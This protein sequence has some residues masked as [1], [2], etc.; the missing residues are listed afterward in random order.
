[1]CPGGVIVAS[2]SSP[3][4]L[5]TNG[6]SNSRHS[7]GFANAAIVTTLAPSAFGSGAFDGVALQE[8]LE[9]A[10]FAAG[11]GDY[12]AP[13]QSAPDFLAGRAGPLTRRS[14]YRFGMTPGRVDALLPPLV[15]DALRHA[16]A[17]FERQIP[18]YAGPEGLLVGLES[19]SSGPVRIPRDADTLRARGFANLFPVG[20]G[21]G[22]AGGIMSAAIDGARAAQVLL[23]D[24]VA[25][26]G[27]RG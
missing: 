2:V 15:R 11:G 26:P 4:L 23:R 1:M 3:G 10:F 16:L 17:R 6:M 18:G 13:A 9:R 25:A 14:S 8:T 24:G 22:Y 19:R 21:A 27:V 5:C 12:T 7:S 20:E